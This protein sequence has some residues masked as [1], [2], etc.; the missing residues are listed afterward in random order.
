MPRPKY[1]WKELFSYSYVADVVSA[2]F[3]ILAKGGSGEAYNIADSNSNI[4]LRDLAELIAVKSGTK[5]VFETPDKIESLGYSN[6]TMA[7]MTAEK[8][9]S[10]G[11]SP[12]YSIEKG[13]SR[14]MDILSS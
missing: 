3:A 5:A 9:Q 7:L 8:L 6:A 4:R 11:W 13:I 12:A 10:L 14:T 2:L 1:L